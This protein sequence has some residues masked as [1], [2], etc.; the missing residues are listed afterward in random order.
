[1]GNKNSVQRGIFVG[2]RPVSELLRPFDAY[3]GAEGGRLLEQALAFSGRMF[4]AEGWLHD[5]PRTKANFPYEVPDAPTLSAQR[6]RFDAMLP[7]I[8]SGDVLVHHY[9]QA[10]SVIRNAHHYAAMQ[11]VSR[12]GLG[13]SPTFSHVSL[14]I[15]GEDGVLWVADFMPAIYAAEHSLKKHL[16][17]DAVCYA[18]VPEISATTNV[19]RRAR[20]ERAAM[21]PRSGPMSPD[22]KGGPSSFGYIPGQTPQGI[23]TFIGDA[24]DVWLP[25]LTDEFGNIIEPTAAAPD[26][27]ARD[28][29]EP[30]RIA[31][32]TLARNHVLHIVPLRRR[33][34]VMQCDTEVLRL[35]SPLNVVERA[36]LNSFVL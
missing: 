34:E 11:P 31:K 33:L 22:E 4:T 28:P 29:D 24:D 36:Q 23:K 21:I 35:R 19:I 25:P 5:P 2:S 14:V 13:R 20:A 18:G 9:R 3:D 17:P 10:P 8:K 16:L 6:A 7:T 32:E 1:M 26:P 12:P 15:R 27:P 30:V